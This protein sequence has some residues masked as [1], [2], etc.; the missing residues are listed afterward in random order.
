MTANTPTRA[1]LSTHENA[2]ATEPRRKPDD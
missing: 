1:E 2:G